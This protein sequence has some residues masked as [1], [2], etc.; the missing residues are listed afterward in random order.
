VSDLRLVGGV[1]GHT[2]SGTRQIG[3]V[4]GA[5]LAVALATG[6]AVAP[7]QE[8]APGAVEGRLTDLYSK[9]LDGV[10]LVLHNALTGA[11]FSTTTSKSGSYRL[12]GLAPGS[13]VL[14][15]SSPRLG[16]GRT[17]GILVSPGHVARI[18]T[19]LALHRFEPT[20]APVLAF[21][22]PT[23]PPHIEA[24]P[25]PQPTLTAALAVPAPRAS[26]AAVL[27]TASLSGARSGALLASVA[28]AS[29]IAAFQF[30]PANARAGGTVAIE[31]ELQPSLDETI[32]GEELEAMPLSARGS[33]PFRLDT[34]PQ[35]PT[36]SDLS[37]SRE[38][39]AEPG[40]R[41]AAQVDG[42]S[43]RLAFGR[44]SGRRDL[45]A[46]SGPAAAESAVREV[47]VIR[48]NGLESSGMSG[49]DGAVRTRG[50]ADFGRGRLHGQLFLFD[51]RNLLNARNPL[52][53]WVKETVPATPGSLPVF[54]P[55]AW[56]PADQALRWGGGGGGPLRRDR[57]FWYGAFSQERR[58]DP[59]VSMVRHSDHFFATPSSD[60]MQVLS[61]R[62]NLSSADPVGEGLAAYSGMLE[63]LDGL[64]GPVARTSSRWTGFG[65]LDWKAASRH[66][67]QMEGSTARWDAPGGGLM[68]AAETYGSHS[69][70]VSKSREVWLMGRWDAVLTPNLIAV[71]QASMGMY[72]MQHPAG[73]PSAFEQR[74]NVNPWGQLPQM[75]V[76]SRYGFSIGNP[77]KFGAGTYPAERMFELREI[78]DWQRGPLVFR[79]GADLRQNADTTSFVRNHTG[80]YHYSRIENFASDALA[81]AKFGLGDAL[82]PVSQHNCDPHGRAWRDTDGRLHGL[83]YLPCYSYY[84]QTIGPTDWHLQTQDWSAFTATEWRA[85]PTLRLSAGVRW[86][87]PTT[88]SSIPLVQN[89]DLPLA[90]KLPAFG[91]QWAP[92]VGLAWGS[93]ESRWPA[94]TL[95]YGM[96]Y[97]RVQNRT[98]EEALT[99]TGSAAGDLKL[100]LR[101]NDNLPLGTG[102]APPFP[103]VLA[104]SPGPALKPGVS[105]IAPGF[106]NGEV[107]QAIASVEK[108]LPGRI[109][110]SV[111][112]V[113]TLGRRLPVTMDT[114]FD[115]AA[116][117]GTITYE[118][119]DAKGLGPIHAPQVTAPF[120]AAW[121]TAGQGGGRLNPNYQEITQLA[122]RANSTYEAGVVRIT[123]RGARGL[124]FNLRYTYGHAMDWNPNESGLLTGGDVLDPLDFRQEYGPSDLDIRHS[125]AGYTI[126]QAPW[127]LRGI[128]GKIVNGWLLSGIGQYHSG[129]P[130]SMRTAGGIPE[131]S[132]GG[133]LAVGL[134]PGMN[135]Y[136][137]ANR[138]YGVGRNTYRYPSTWKADVRLGKRFALGHERELQ[139]I[140]QSFNL[141][142][143][144][145]VTE[146]ETVGYTL[147]T[148]SAP[149]S[150]P[151]LNFLMN[152]TT[153]LPEFGLPLNVNATDDY[154]ER[155]FDF[156]LRLR[157]RH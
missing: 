139:L 68:R 75:V 29:L 106:R 123:R 150:L 103:Y 39:L 31:P 34:P 126:W 100:L 83:G 96:Y 141:F 20:S 127:R 36:G 110:L 7:A 35:P 97:G 99:Q 27:L 87:R 117:P 23:P 138:V 119:M 66:R 131:M 14:E 48:S 108:T 91:N 80:T 63:T 82:D 112:A 71:A 4:A 9:P 56:S 153:G 113:A 52:T 148:A 24:L 118:V 149:G 129:L 61:A 89:P 95:G 73:T 152:A 22:S 143:H 154:R 60:E 76:D 26:P 37:E 44:G 109:D 54:T 62:L 120:Y 86:S 142:N 90:G 58:N 8:L 98:L 137:G 128:G 30:G 94:V 156:G 42:M 33:E 67:F 19:A 111:S 147:D 16:S 146:I 133:G 17:S 145:N 55:F 32:S 115:P 2:G 74:L 13:Y 21:G 15:A 53:E 64:L 47:Q 50:G 46:F 28:S 157:F 78:I 81:F 1:N 85:R 69:F 3:R 84:T 105:E 10:R 5:L 130:Y 51:R 12:A 107:Q 43:M 114:N 6:S 102:G 101:P 57:L 38:N 65:R 125:I 45:G 72:T 132:Q 11:E 140:A 18:Q 40:D 104:G 136:G 124:G 25:A 122:S 121:P 144:G 59:A 155:Q 70:A 134:G 79:A 77:A 41:P 93:R 88:P 151:R 135:G 49:T 116:N 92:R